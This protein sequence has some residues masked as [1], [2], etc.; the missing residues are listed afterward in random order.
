M[1]TT[2]V[3]DPA[4]RKYGAC[5]CIGTDC[6]AAVKPFFVIMIFSLA[7]F[8]SFD[9]QV[10]HLDVLLLSTNRPESSHAAQRRCHYGLQARSV[11]QATF[12]LLWSGEWTASGPL[13]AS[14]FDPLRRSLRG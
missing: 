4:S 13:P 9:L 5:G 3:P 12:I 8:S 1:Q 11:L 14:I 2:D 10:S 7:Y 6:S